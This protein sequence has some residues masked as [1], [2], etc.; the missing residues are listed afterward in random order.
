ME[1]KDE[2]EQHPDLLYSPYFRAAT[3]IYSTWIRQGRLKPAQTRDRLEGVQGTLRFA[4][5]RA[6][7]TEYNKLQADFIKIAEWID[8]ATK[9]AK[10]RYK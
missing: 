10:V 9:A 6:K 7:G 8:E 3:S 2:K 5:M 4:L 1:I